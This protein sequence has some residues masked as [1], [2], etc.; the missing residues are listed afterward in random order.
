[1]SG[2]PN[3]TDI[4]GWADELATVATRLGPRF[5]RSEPRQRAV[6][7]LRALLGDAQRKNGWQRAEYRGEA[8]PDGVPHLTGPRRRGRRIGGAP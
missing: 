3:A 4:Q 7:S 8:N 5:T 2:R 6:G 1:M